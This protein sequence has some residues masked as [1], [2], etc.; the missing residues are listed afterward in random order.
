[1][2]VDD[3]QL[4]S[5]SILKFSSKRGIATSLMVASLGRAFAN[6]EGSIRYLAPGLSITDIFEEELQ[7]IAQQLAREMLG[8]DAMARSAAHAFLMGFN[9]P[10]RCGPSSPTWPTA[11]RRCAPART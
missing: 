9:G 2:P 11:T 10:G 5:P 6:A 3:C 8:R 4:V 1:M 7:L